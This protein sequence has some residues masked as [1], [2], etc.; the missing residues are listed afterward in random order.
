MLTALR[1]DGQPLEMEWPYLDALPDNLATYTPPQ[2]MAVF[3]RL[4]ETLPPTLDVIVDH[5]LSGGTS[6]LV[7]MTGCRPEGGGNLVR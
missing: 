2:G 5:L 3:R 1:E 7:T 4:G 6:L